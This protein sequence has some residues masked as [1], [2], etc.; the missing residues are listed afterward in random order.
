MAGN[1]LHMWRV[2]DIAWP[3]PM[4]AYDAC[5]QNVKELLRHGVRVAGGV[6]AF[7]IASSCRSL[8]IRDVD[9]VAL[10]L[11]SGAHPRRHDGKNALLQVE[12][13][14]HLKWPH[15]IFLAAALDMLSSTLPQATVLL[16]D[17][18]DW[19]DSVLIPLDH[20]PLITFRSHYGTFD[21][22]NFRSEASGFDDRHVRPWDTNRFVGCGLAGPFLQPFILGQKEIDVPKL[23]S[24]VAEAGL[25]VIFVGEYTCAQSRHCL[26]RALADRTPSLRMLC[27]RPWETLPEPK[28]GWKRG[29]EDVY[30]LQ[31]YREDAREKV[32]KRHAPERWPFTA[33]HAANN[34][35]KALPRGRACVSD[36]GHTMWPAV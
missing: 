14:T 34:W 13:R 33:M 19:A 9:S 4:A 28:R 31:Q 7:D 27:D 10:V 24:L 8:G 20:K 12:L 16:C 18:G 6:D 23:A 21:G 17:E 29:A 2:T 35:L 1:A 11:W 3:T 30:S 36:F 22:Q 25:H 15:T 32:R 5:M 26:R